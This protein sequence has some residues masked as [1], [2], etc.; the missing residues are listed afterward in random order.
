MGERNGLPEL[1]ADCVELVPIKDGKWE[2]GCDATPGAT[3]EVWSSPSPDYE[4]EDGLHHGDIRIEEFA[5][6]EDWV[7]RLKNSK[8]LQDDA[9]QKLERV[10]DGWKE[11]QGKT[12]AERDTQTVAFDS[13][14]KQAETAQELCRETLAQ[15]DALQSDV[16]RLSE[17]SCDECVDGSGQYFIDGKPHPCVCVSETEPYQRLLTA[18]ETAQQYIDALEGKG[19]DGFCIEAKTRELIGF[20]QFGV[21]G[22]E[23]STG[24]DYEPIHDAIYDALVSAK[25]MGRGVAAGER[26]RMRGILQTCHKE[27]DA[28]WSFH[29]QGLEVTGWHKNGDAE[30]FDNF[31]EENDQG[32]VEASA[33]FLDDAEEDEAKKDV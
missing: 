8:V 33:E 9:F 27:L 3:H 6:L 21:M 17:L 4:G 20:L 29:G 22:E 10:C 11:L 7:K 13:A 31:L 14:V 25:T 23:P 12:E 28:I 15:R 16:D 18:L 30:P 26:E 24:D 19:E 2:K 1:R 5:Q 32:A